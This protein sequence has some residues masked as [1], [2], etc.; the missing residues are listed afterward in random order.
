M[1][2]HGF[3]HAMVDAFVDGAR[4][5]LTGVVDFLGSFVD[6]GSASLVRLLAHLQQASMVDLRRIDGASGKCKGPE[7]PDPR[8]GKRPEIQSSSGGLRII[9]PFQERFRHALAQAPSIKRTGNMRI[10]YEGNHDARNE[11]IGDGAPDEPRCQSDPVFDEDSENQPPKAI[12]G[13][14]VVLKARR[15]LPHLEGGLSD[16]ATNDS[17]SVF[18]QRRA[19]GT[20][21]AR[22]KPKRRPRAAYKSLT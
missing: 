8:G 10:I 9:A 20:F 3:G 12:G 4:H 5:L 19:P 22:E 15:L 2:V 21:S 17:N 18:A 6:V 11:R 13:A 1:K 14:I 7:L 16:S